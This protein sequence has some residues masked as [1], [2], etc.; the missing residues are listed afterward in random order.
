MHSSRMR[1]VHSSSRLPGG[2]GMPQCM[3]GYTHPGPG[4]GQPWAWKPPQAWAWKSPDRPSNLPSLGLD[5][6]TPQADS[7]TSPLFLGLNTPSVNR[8]TDRQVKKHYLRKLRLRM[9]RDI[10]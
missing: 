7:L 3:L 9:V 8:M 4:P 5:L 1:T 6:D 2:R 10:G